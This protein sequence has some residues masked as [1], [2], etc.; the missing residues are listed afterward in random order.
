MSVLLV[1][2]QRDLD[3]LGIKYLH[4]YLLD[5]G[6]ASRLLFMPE[7][8]RRRED[9]LRG[10]AAFARAWKPD[11]VA[12]SLMSLEYA[13]ATDATRALRD[14]LPG[15]PVVWGGIHATSD[16]TSCLTGNRADFVCV[17]EGERTMLDLAR[18]ARS[19]RDFR[20]IPNLGWVED[21]R[22]TQNPVYPL[23]R[24]LDEL[25]LLRRIAPESYLA[26]PE[27]VR[28]LEEKLFRRW[29]RHA[30]K[31]YITIASRGCPYGCAYCCNNRYRKLYEDWNVRR[32][33]VDHIIRELEQALA[34]F[35]G[36]EYVNFH[37]DCFLACPIEYLREFCG[38]YKKRVNRPLIAKSTP[39]YV[40]EERLTLLKDAG[41]SW[42]SLGLQSGSE[43]VCQE[44]YNRRSLPKH[45]LEAARMIHR[46]GIAPFYDVILDNPFESEAEQLET[47]RTLIETPKPYY[48][49]IFS[50][51]FYE[52]TALRERAEKECPEVIEDPTEKDYRIRHRRLVNDL[53]ETATTLPAFLM[54]PLLRRYER[55][56]DSLLTRFLVFAAKWSTRVFFTPLTYL[57]VIRVSQRGSWIR[58]FRVLPNYFKVGFTY[59]LHLFRA[60]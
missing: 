3:V 35:P 49:E 11:L 36:V 24:D 48:P 28:P 22:Y 12:V 17:G 2:V 13:D 34:D 5:R 60:R 45:F 20:S 56:P 9:V 59:Y 6:E 32:R 29:A 51:V 21:G 33:S 15:V 46:F 23:I 41:L 8:R 47:V 14:A 4:Q 10:A 26:L 19:G 39:T 57:R 50:L 38:E 18:A 27:G 1:T 7:L 25:P 53:V 42:I 43:R 54:R 31:N 40:T 44:V 16:P 30:G 58:T 55:Y 37:D 52:G